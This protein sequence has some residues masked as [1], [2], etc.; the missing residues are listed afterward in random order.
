MEDRIRITWDKNLETGDDVIDGQHR[1]L[2][3]RI[4]KLL[5][6]SRERRSREEVAQTLTFLGDYV[7]HHFNAEERMMEAARYPEIEAH[8]AEHARFVQEFGILYNE[9]KSE[10]PT[11]LFIIRIGNRITGWLR[12]HIYRTDRTLV[13]YLKQH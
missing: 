8:R 10:G 6:A 3:F 9:F 12:E 11:T 7:V 5:A 2:F 13:E 1:E 4:D